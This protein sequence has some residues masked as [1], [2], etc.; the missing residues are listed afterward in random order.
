M[1][2]TAVGDAI[3]QKRIPGDD[4]S[5]SQLTDYINQGDARFFNLETTLFEKGECYAS[6]FSGGTYLRTTPK[7]LDDLIPYGFN[8]TSFNNNHC[9]DFSYD[10]L[11]KTL[12][13]VEKSGLVH[14]GVGRSLEEA[15]CPKYLKTDKGTVALI[16]FNTTFE[17]CTIAGDPA[18]FVP[19]RPGVNGL[20]IEDYISVSEAEFNHLKELADSTGVNDN[21]KILIRE[22][23]SLGDTGDEFSFGK[24]K[25]IKGEKNQVIQK[26]KKADLIR[27]EKAIKEAKEK[28]DEVI[29]SLHTHQIF[30][31][32]KETVPPVLEE[33]SRFCIDCGAT[34]VIGHGPH[35][36]RGIEI[37]KE[38]PIF[39]SLGDFILQLYGVEYAPADF[40]AK[41]G[42]TPD[43]G[44]QNLLKT[45]SKNFTIGLMEQRV[46]FQSVIPY[47]ET[48]NG[49]LKFLELLPIEL[50]MQG[51]E[52]TQGLPRIAEDTAFM[53]KLADMSAQYGTKIILQD[54]KY[55]VKW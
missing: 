9:M 14:A 23:Y 53:D 10:G 54:G 2:F 18:P 47:W 32:Y 43:V 38:C 20:T 52:N 42:L 35:L 46:M 1:K 12:D 33:F 30:G 27:A 39:Y 5:Y 15:S 17:A 26:V 41:Y 50:L 51:E 4:I 45:R 28:A 44:V 16:S 36:L 37:Y 7:A 29:I 55:I 13:S 11:L 22:G 49:K 31:E 3:I 8:L 21:E 6:Q 34:A 48:E 40:Y 19:A 24:T 25:F